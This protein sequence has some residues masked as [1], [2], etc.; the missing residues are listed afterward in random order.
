MHNT[1]PAMQPPAMQPFAV[2]NPTRGVW[3]TAQL[4]LSGRPAVLGDLADLELDARWIGLPASLVGAPHPR[5]RIFIVAHR[6]GDVQDPSRH[7]LDP[8]RRDFGARTGAAR[9]DRALASGHRPGAQRTGWLAEQEQRVGDA[10]VPDRGHLPRRGGYA[11]AIARWEHITGR[12][13]PAPALLTESAGPRPSP[14]FVEWLMGLP[15]DWVVQPSLG[16]TRN[17][18]TTALGNGVLPLQ[19]SCA[20]KSTVSV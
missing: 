1:T 10:V 17:E 13:A 7:G 4:D 3:E 11:G 12:P 5:L 18:Q 14:A 9:D 16:L 8:W 20:I 2:W 6:K 19:A 15:A